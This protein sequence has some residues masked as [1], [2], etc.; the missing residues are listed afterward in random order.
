M[1]VSIPITISKAGGEI[2]PVRLTPILCNEDDDLY[3][4]GCEMSDGSTPLV[5]LHDEY[6]AAED[7]GTFDVGMPTQCSENDFSYGNPVSADDIEG[8][9]EEFGSVVATPSFDSCSRVGSNLETKIVLTINGVSLVSPQETCAIDDVHT[10]N[11]SDF[12]LMQ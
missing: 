8:A 5:V 6:G 7:D 11:A 12:E 1:T 3:V 10:F 9:I 4:L 2:T